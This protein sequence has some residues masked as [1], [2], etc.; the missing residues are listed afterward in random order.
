MGD[1]AAT[2]DCVAETPPAVTSTV[3]VCAIATPLIVADTVFDPAAVEERV[4]VATPLAS[5]V[6]TGWVSVLPVVGVAARTTVAPWIGLP[7]ASLAVTVIVEVP[8][9]ATIGE[10]AASVDCPAETGPTFTRTVAV[11]VIARPLAVADTVFDPAAVELNVPVA[12]PFASVV[13]A[14]WVSVFP[15]VGVAASVTVAPFTGLPPA[16]LTVT[17]MVLEPE[18]AVMLPGAAA[19]DDCD[20]LGPPAVALARNTTG[21]PAR[22]GAVARRVSVPDVGPSVHEV[23]GAMPLASLETGVVGLTVP[24]P[25]AGVKVTA[26]PATGFP[27]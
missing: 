6:P 17:V 23:S 22:P 19:T 1:V 14:G 13:A 20:A 15:V 11:C 3:A 21:L 16:S 8:L 24:L 2:V 27:N 25:A 26:T 7:F 12:W 5:V 18:P 9:P 4:P 10:V